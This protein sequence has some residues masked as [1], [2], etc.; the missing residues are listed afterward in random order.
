VSNPFDNFIGSPIDWDNMGNMAAIGEITIRFKP[1]EIRDQI[2]TS[3]IDPNDLLTVA[4]T[5]IELSFRDHGKVALE[6]AIRQL[7]A[8]PTRIAADIDIVSAKRNLCFLLEATRDSLAEFDLIKKEPRIV[9][10]DP[11]LA[12]AVAEGLIN[13]ERFEEAAFVIARIDEIPFAVLSER[14]AKINGW[15]EGANAMRAEAYKHVRW[16]ELPGWWHDIGRGDV[17]RAIPTLEENLQ[18]RVGM[19]HDDTLWLIRGLAVAGD[20]RAIPVLK[21]AL[22]HHKTNVVTDAALALHALGDDAGLQTLL[23]GL[24]SCGESDAW[25]FTGALRC[26]RDARAT[27]ALAE[28]SASQRAVE[29]RKRASEELKQR[30]INEGLCLTCGKALGFMDKMSGRQIHK[31]CA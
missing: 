21:Q 25:H 22:R 6:E 8:N 17:R 26:I 13:K 30:R 29:E 2:R 5:L 23:S 16:N 7:D 14:L 11:Q 27:T 19:G 4:G 28:Y 10:A 9:Q 15:V 3:R 12:L 20:R 18:R 24:R 1:D 31:Q